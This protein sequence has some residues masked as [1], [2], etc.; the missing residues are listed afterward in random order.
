MPRLGPC[1]VPVNIR[2]FATLDFQSAPQSRRIA[3]G[4][5]VSARSGKMFDMQSVGTPFHFGEPTSSTT[6]AAFAQARFQNR[7]DL[8]F[9]V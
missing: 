6:E 4:Q 9:K 2:P 5:R 1:D 8:R 3:S 7:S